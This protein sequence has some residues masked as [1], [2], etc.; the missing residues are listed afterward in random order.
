MAEAFAGVWVARDTSGKDVSGAEASRAAAAVV[1]RWRIPGETAVFDVRADGT[2]TWGPRINGSYRML[3][4]QRVRMTVVENGKPA[5][6]LDYDVLVE[7]GALKL[8]LPDGSVTTYE[9]AE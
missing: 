5:G 1:G 2:Y 9:R 8:K 7:G 4:A 6:Y 3:Q